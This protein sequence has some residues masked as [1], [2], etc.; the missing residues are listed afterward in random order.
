[1][2]WALTDPL[3]PTAYPLPEGGVIYLTERSAMTD[4]STGQAGAEI[5]ITPAMIEAGVAV[6]WRYNP[7]DD[8]ASDAVREIIDTVFRAMASQPDQACSR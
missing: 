7:N 8:V 2:G 6:L 1:M 4:D 3:N 5:E